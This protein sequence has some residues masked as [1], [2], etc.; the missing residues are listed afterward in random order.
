[1]LLIDSRLK[2]YKK[3]NPQKKTLFRYNTGKPGIAF[4]L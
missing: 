4:P 2:C 3:V 1:M